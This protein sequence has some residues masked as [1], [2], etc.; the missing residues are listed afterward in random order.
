MYQY[1]T[2]FRAI[3]MIALATQLLACAKVGLHGRDPAQASTKN[4]TPSCTDTDFGDQ[5][6]GTPPA[7]PRT[8]D[9]A[10]GYLYRLT[11]IQDPKGW[12]AHTGNYNGVPTASSMDLISSGSVVHDLD[13]YATELNIDTRQWIDGFPGYPDF[14]EWFGLCYDGTWTAP[15]DGN[16]TIVTAVDDGMAVFIDGQLVGE[17]DDG[18]LSATI[19]ASYPGLA[20]S[21]APKAF[22]PITL[23]AGPHSVQVK[24]YQA[25]PTQLRAQLW[26]GA[27]LTAAGVT[28]ADLMSFT[29]P[30]NGQVNC[31]H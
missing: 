23:T 9:K 14:T 3:S 18:N 13:Y 28:A 17:N 1:K 29:A 30:Q 27:G 16:Y 2:V 7:T 24:Y 6:T 11:P 15:S 19:L 12:V 25:W 20:Y 4:P 8:P 26:A 5:C 22:P 31:P 10:H 21:N